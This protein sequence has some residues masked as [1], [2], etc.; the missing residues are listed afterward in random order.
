MS[1]MNTSLPLLSAITDAEL[2]ATD[3][4]NLSRISST[5]PTK[6]ASSVSSSGSFTYAPSPKKLFSPEG[7]TPEV[8]INGTFV[9]S[10]SMQTISPAPKFSACPACTVMNVSP[11]ET[12]P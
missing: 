9:F 1:E 6:K 8:D 12:S 7:P 5:C 2:L 10:G 3:T 11:A 4:Y